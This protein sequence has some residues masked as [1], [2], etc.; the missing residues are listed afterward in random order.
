MVT[1]QKEHCGEKEVKYCLSETFPKHYGSGKINDDIYLIFEDFM[2]GTNF[3]VTDKKIEVIF[4]QRIATTSKE[5]LNIIVNDF[6]FPYPMHF[7]LGLRFLIRI[8]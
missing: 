5:N 1:F 2:K 8:K 7:I 6:L 3:K 4:V